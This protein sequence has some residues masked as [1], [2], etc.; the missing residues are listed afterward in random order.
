MYILYNKQQQKIFLKFFT[1]TNTEF[2]NS[3]KNLESLKLTIR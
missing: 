3:S 1:V 2:N